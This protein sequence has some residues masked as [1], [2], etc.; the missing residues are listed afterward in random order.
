[1]KLWAR[2]YGVIGPARILRMQ[3]FFLLIMKYFFGMPAFHGCHLILYE[4]LL[5]GSRNVT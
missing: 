5:A 1:L 2:G 4:F 3:V